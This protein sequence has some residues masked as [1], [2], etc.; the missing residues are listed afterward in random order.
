MKQGSDTHNESFCDCQEPV[1]LQEVQGNTI[2]IR[3]D[4]C[5]YSVVSTYQSAIE[6]DQTS[7]L[8]Q[9][10]TR[11]N[12]I[13]SLIQF[14]KQKNDLGTSQARRFIQD[15]KIVF[16]YQGSGYDF[17]LFVQQLAKQEISYRCI[18]TYPH[19]IQYQV[20][21]NDTKTLLSHH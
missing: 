11:D 2:I 5:S 13:L 9:V 1:F 16:E 6:L 8:L 19:F 4:L 7:Y 18:P 3:C 12:E 21:V 15:H 17:Y 20:Q 10:Y 14:I